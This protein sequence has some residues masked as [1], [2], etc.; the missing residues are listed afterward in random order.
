MS[1][2]ISEKDR[3]QNSC[4]SERSEESYDISELEILRYAQD[5][6]Y[7][8]REDRKGVF[9]FI[10]FFADSWRPLRECLKLDLGISGMMAKN[11]I[12]KI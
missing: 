6:K 10:A 4:H 12:I 8:S 5:D 9:S 11:K 2:R 1:K 7:S 3:K